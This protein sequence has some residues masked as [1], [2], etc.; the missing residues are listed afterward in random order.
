M[1]I[2]KIERYRSIMLKQL[3]NGGWLIAQ[4]A[5]EYGLAHDELAAYST[6]GEMLDAL[7]LAL[8]SEPR[9]DQTDER[10]PFR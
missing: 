9:K 1:H 3:P 2:L 5:S 10:P 6:C 8:V 4:P 7:R